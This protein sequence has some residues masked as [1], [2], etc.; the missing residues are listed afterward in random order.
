[1]RKHFCFL[2]VVIFFLSFSV[3]AKNKDRA[4][5]AISRTE[6]L[7]KHIEHKNFKKVWEMFASYRRRDMGLDK[8]QY[9]ATLKLAFAKR[10]KISYGK[11]KLI[12]QG[13][14]YATIEVQR[15]I[16]FIEGIGEAPITECERMLLVWEKNNWFFDTFG[17]TCDFVPD[18]NLIERL[19]RDR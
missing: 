2:L 14:N 11:P 6:R 4:Q 7:L 9:S 1:M 19:E 3:S 12:T 10:I 13:K 17:V 5:E 15:T 16:F 8:K 18:K